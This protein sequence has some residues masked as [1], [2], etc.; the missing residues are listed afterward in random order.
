MTAEGAIRWAVLAPFIGVA[1]LM[2]TPGLAGAE[3][4]SASDSQARKERLELMKRQAAEYTLT[5]DAR[6]STAKPTTLALHDEPILRFSNPVS[7]VPDGIVVMWKH[8]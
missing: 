1:Y 8:G 2:A 3:E 5:L 6:N 7:G 4:P